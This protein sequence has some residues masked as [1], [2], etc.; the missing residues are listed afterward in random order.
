MNKAR[1]IDSVFAFSAPFQAFNNG[2]INLI[3]LLTD[4]ESLRV[5]WQSFLPVHHRDPHQTYP[6]IEA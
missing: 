3:R 4:R 2:A 5:H 1:K 6:T